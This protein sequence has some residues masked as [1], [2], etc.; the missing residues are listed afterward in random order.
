MSGAR[1]WRGSRC[2]AAALLR[3]RCAFRLAGCARAAHAFQLAR[4]RECQ[5][6]VVQLR[7]VSQMVCEE[8]G[9]AA[10]GGYGC[11]TAAAG[12]VA[13]SWGQNGDLER[14]EGA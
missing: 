1:R 2:G 8:G 11:W 12:T 3:G 4:I 13:M 6:R 10:A 14:A 5:R 9:A 7:C